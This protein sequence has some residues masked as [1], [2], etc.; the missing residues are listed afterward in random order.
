MGA[1]IR[2]KHVSNFPIDICAGG[3]LGTIE[4]KPLPPYSSQALEFLSALSKALLAKPGS[5]KYPDIA[6]FAFW[7]RNA[8]LSRLEREFDKRFRRLGRGLVLH[9]APANVPVN[10]AFSFAFGVLS[11]CANI[12]RIPA[13]NHPQVDI[14]CEEISRLFDSSAHSQIAAMNR[15]IKYPRN[16]EITVALSASCQ[17][18]VLWGG[19]IT[20]T[21]L[22]AI[23]TSP[24]CIDIAFAD[25]YSFC[26]MGA[27]AVLHSDDAILKELVSGF[28]ND[29]FFLDQNA[30]SSPHLILWQGHA[31]HVE[32]AMRRFWS[33]LSSLV[34]EKFEL[35]PIHAIDKFAHMCRTAILL[36]EAG[37]LIREANL[38]YRIRLDNLPS[39]IEFHRGQHGFFYEY[40]TE[41]LNCFTKIVNERY[42]T[43]TYFGVDCEVLAE[44]VVNEGLTGIDRIVPVGK[45]LDIGVIW[46]GYDLISTLSRVIH[47]L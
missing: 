4:S 35:A 28:Y 25:R 3:P 46:D 33:V 36:P 12:V 37:A 19:D 20:I 42:Q 11:G 18:R 34:H 7:C 44:F 16:D 15:L 14:L 5:R 40:I 21:Q 41:D 38:I 27:E 24:R 1:V 23:P 2:M 26:I 10:F 39:D 13:A 30:C 43:L 8:N 17:A 6:A 9:I 32:Q 47:T 45:A 29:V 22:R 31:Q